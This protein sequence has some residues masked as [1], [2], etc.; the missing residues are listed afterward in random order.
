MPP[1]KPHSQCTLHERTRAKGSGVFAVGLPCPLP[2]VS[3]L[4]GGADAL[5]CPSSLG[6]VVA[7]T[8]VKP[9]MKRP[10]ALHA[11]LACP[12]CSPCGPRE[13]APQEGELGLTVEACEPRLACPPVNGPRQTPKHLRPPRF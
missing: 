9:R 1:P 6:D 10:H 8:P 13:Q 2:G 4:L 3:D 12:G 11:L 5:P 7:A